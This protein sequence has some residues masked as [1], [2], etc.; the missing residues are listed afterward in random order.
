LQDYA[1][2]L[3]SRLPLLQDYA[4]L[5]DKYYDAAHGSRIDRMVAK[6]KMTQDPLLDASIDSEIERRVRGLCS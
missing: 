6:N 4:R 2:C 5:F 1:Y 3:Y